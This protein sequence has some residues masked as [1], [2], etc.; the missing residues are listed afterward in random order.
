[1]K[2]TSSK[3]FIFLLSILFIGDMLDQVRA[4]SEVEKRPL[5]SLPAWNL[6]ALID[7]SLT[8]DL[9]NY[10]NDQFI[11]RDEWVRFK[12][13]LE[14]SMGKKENNGII[15]GKD[16]I[17]FEKRLVLS[18]QASL[19]L[20]Y[21]SEFLEL[22]KTLPITVALV[23]NKEAILKEALPTGFPML[24]SLEV[25]K[26]WRKT[27]PIADLSAQMLSH[28]D[29]KLFYDTDHHWT[30]RGAYLAYEQLMT[31]WGMTA[32]PYESFGVQQI[33][34]FLGTL[35]NKSRFNG[36]KSETL[37]W[38][39]PQIL[40]YETDGK[41]TGSLIDKAALTSKDPYSA[42]LYG[43]HGFGRILV[44]NSITPKKLLVIKDSYANSLIPFMTSA[45]D[46]IDVIDLRQ[47]NGS[48]KGILETNAYD[49][50]LV[51][52]SFNQFCDEVNEAKL[53]Y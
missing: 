25:L 50:I 23:P 9:E 38:I 51:L 48:L 45:F 4:Y 31:M 14:S 42:F 30:L 16:G 3:L 43:N 15:L 28:L 2:N 35:Y 52:Q 13:L 39:D 44:N 6:E 10:I 7:G 41:V 21:L 40:S 5:A 37:S 53:R 1:M 8:L 27:L 22:Y 12:A 34:G 19:N 32:L 49:K 17:L 33:D 18:D 26:S 36:I 46:Q 29:E 20:H 11:G 47:F 24:D